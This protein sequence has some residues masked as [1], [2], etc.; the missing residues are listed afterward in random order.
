VA[1]PDQPASLGEYDQKR[2]FSVT[3]EPVPTA[4]ALPSASPRFMVH[5]HHARR[6][7][8]DLR[9]EID[10]ALASWA[11]PR[12]PSYDPAV[13][14]LAVQTEDHPLAYGDFEGRIP[15]GQYG[16]GD[17][18]V[19]DRG[20]FD[21]VP[22]GQVAAQ[23]RKGH[24]HFAL[25][26]EKLRGEWHLLRTTAANGRRA[27]QGDATASGPKSQW[28]MIKLDDEEADPSLDIVVAH[29]ESVL[30][31]RVETRGPEPVGRGHPNT[32][33][34]PSMPKLL[35]TGVL[36]SEHQDSASTSDSPRGLVGAPITRKPTPLFARVPLHALQ[37]DI[38]RPQA[39]LD[40]PANLFDEPLGK[41]AAAQNIGTQTT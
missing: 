2:D 13:K 4:A 27:A 29:P 14:R 16:A 36:G 37:I 11:V 9:L 12:G 1:K 34:K 21:T 15:D 23:R 40:L 31:G 22:P 33:A 28:L 8:Y 19:W 3:S 5:K 38:T 30:S 26:G 32:G 17:S 41:S 24:I 7:H 6:L 39:L 25:A 10:G 18:M 35:K 20:H